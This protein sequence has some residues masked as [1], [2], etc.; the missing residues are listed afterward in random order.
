MPTGCEWEA[1]LRMGAEEDALARLP[2][3]AFDCNNG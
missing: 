1:Q 2:A 3:L